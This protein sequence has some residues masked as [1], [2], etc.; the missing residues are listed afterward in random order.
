MCSR[1][2]II[3]C[4]ALNIET[5]SAKWSEL[6]IPAYT[7]ESLNMCILIYINL[8]LTVSHFSFRLAFCPVFRLDTHPAHPT[9][10]IVD[11]KALC[12]W[13]VR[14][15]CDFTQ[16]I[17]LAEQ[18]VVVFDY[19]TEEAE[20]LRVLKVELQEFLFL[21]MVPTS[22]RILLDKLYLDNGISDAAITI[23]VSIVKDIVELNSKLFD[24]FD[25]KF[26]V[27]IL[28]FLYMNVKVGH[29]VV[30]MGAY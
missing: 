30:D 6:L 18:N 10:F 1:K 24:F 3:L 17:F 21:G 22:E 2:D 29:K 15:I 9:N 8:N 11:H 12:V 14:L 23:F 7:W 20:E 16:T 27:F 19:S 13:N 25:C 26:D 5:E 4:P 28:L